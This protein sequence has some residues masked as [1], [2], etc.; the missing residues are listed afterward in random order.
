MIYLI[1]N[2]KLYL[3]PN[4]SPENHTN[5]YI[6]QQSLEVTVTVLKSMTK[7]KHPDYIWESVVQQDMRVKGLTW[8]S[9]LSKYFTISFNAF[10]MTNLSLLLKK[11]CTRHSHL[12]WPHSESNIQDGWTVPD[13]SFPI[14]SF[15][16]LR[17]QISSVASNCSL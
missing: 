12:K 11:N 7:H 3:S 10:Q 17:E 8:K 16:E 6:L 2:K 9:Y 15:E 1:E 13:I 5:T 4:A 14:Q